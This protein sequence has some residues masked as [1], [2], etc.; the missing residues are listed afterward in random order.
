MEKGDV[1]LLEDIEVK[2]IGEYVYDLEVQFPDIPMVAKPLLKK[3]EKHYLNLRRCYTQRLRSLIWLKLV[4]R[5]KCIK[6][7]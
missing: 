5:N 7:F 1:I 3:A 4:Y 6:L 2:N